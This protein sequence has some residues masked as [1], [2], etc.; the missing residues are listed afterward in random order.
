MQKCNAVT[1][2]TVETSE[3]QHAEEEPQGEPDPPTQKRAPPEIKFILPVAYDDTAVATGAR[4]A[5]TPCNA[6]TKDPPS[7]CRRSCTRRRSRRRA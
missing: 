5:V 2:D 3:E 4:G 1:K 6:A 7:R